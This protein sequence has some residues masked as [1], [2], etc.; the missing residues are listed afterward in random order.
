MTKNKKKPKFVSTPLEIASLTG[1]DP[2]CMPS[3]KVRDLQ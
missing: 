3:H 1:S 2:L